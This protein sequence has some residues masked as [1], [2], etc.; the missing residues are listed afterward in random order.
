M[1]IL[2]F[3]PFFF[4]GVGLEGYIFMEKSPGF[5]IGKLGNYVFVPFLVTTERLSNVGYN[6][7]ENL[8]V[9]GKE[10]ELLT[11]FRDSI[12]NV[13]VEKIEVMLNII[14]RSLKNLTG[15]VKLYHWVL[16]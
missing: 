2:V 11:C 12:Q 13:S 1:Y 8:V 10:P 15:W 9:S 14:N 6:V 4:E 7:I 5:V 3:I 16:M